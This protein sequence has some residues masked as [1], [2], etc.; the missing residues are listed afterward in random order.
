MTKTK[1]IL[2]ELLDRGYHVE[3]ELGRLESDRKWS[4]DK[5]D[6]D[7]SLNWDE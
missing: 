2:M 4:G 3:E 7:F 6:I 1:L 5:N